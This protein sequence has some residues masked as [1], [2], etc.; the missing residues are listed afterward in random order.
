M[1][2]ETIR[3]HS[4]EGNRPLSEI[5]LKSNDSNI[6]ISS[7]VD[8]RKLSHELNTNKLLELQVTNEDDKEIIEV[9]VVSPVKSNN[10]AKKPLLFEVK[11]H[12]FYS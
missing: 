6:E 7:K 2:Q 1:V 3:A 8:G 9:E 10:P 12:H 5:Q 4:R 11:F